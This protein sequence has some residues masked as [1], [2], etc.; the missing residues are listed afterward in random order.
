MIAVKYLM[1]GGSRFMLSI[2]LLEDCKF[3]G[4]EIFDDGRKRWNIWSSL[5]NDYIQ[6]TISYMSDQIL[7]L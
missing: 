6:L 1:L 7:F 3:N 4:I 5:I 2:I